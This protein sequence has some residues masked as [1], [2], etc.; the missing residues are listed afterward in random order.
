M[1]AGIPVVRLDFMDLFTLFCSVL[2][3]KRSCHTVTG[4]D[5]NAPHM[6]NRASDTVEC[7]PAREI[8]KMETVL[9]EVAHVPLGLYNYSSLVCDAEDAGGST[10]AGSRSSSKE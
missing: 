10:K 2:H 1:G 8:V 7:A 9:H 5:F 3:S 6:N 4:A